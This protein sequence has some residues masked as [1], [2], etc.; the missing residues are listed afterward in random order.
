MTVFA[1]RNRLAAVDSV[2]L[3][4]MRIHIHAPTIA[5]GGSGG[6][7]HPCRVIVS[8]DAEPPDLTSR[9]SSVTGSLSTPIT[10]Q[11]AAQSQ[12]D[13]HNPWPPAS[14]HTQTRTRAYVLYFY[15]TYLLAV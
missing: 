7:S 6:F 14:K 4:P 13:W 5:E 8:K 2:R 1:K 10:E 9:N 12:R 11:K 15:V 3:A